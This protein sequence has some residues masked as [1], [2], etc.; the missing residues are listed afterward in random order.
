MRSSRTALS[1]GDLGG[2]PTDIVIVSDV[3]RILT[4]SIDKSIASKLYTRSK[5]LSS[6]TTG[7]ISISRSSASSSVNTRGL[8]DV[9][10][11]ANDIDEPFSLAIGDAERGDSKSPA[12][13][14]DS[15]SEN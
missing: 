6:L 12:S 9:E 13:A 7:V 2:R 14:S 5:L 8:P 11:P 1:T 3:V 4:S 10:P 15:G